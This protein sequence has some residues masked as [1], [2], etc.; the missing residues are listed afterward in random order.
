MDYETFFFT[1]IAS[2]TVFT[3]CL[4]LLAV[5][6]R[7]MVGLRWFAGALVVG[8]LKLILQGLEGHAP[9]V[10]T[11]MVSNELYLI[12]FAMQFLGFYWF[13]VRQPFRWRWPFV[14]LAVVLAVYTALFIG[15]VPYMGNVLNLPFI[16]LCGGSAWLL[17]RRGKGAFGRLAHCTA[18]VLIGDMGV[19]GYRAVLTNQHY[20]RPWETVNAHTDPRWLYSLAAMAFLATFMAM[21]FLWF[22]VAELGRVLEVQ[23]LTDPLTGA[24]NRRAMEEIALRETARSIRYGHPLSMI[25][26]DIDHFKYLND[27]RGHAAGDCALQALSARISATLRTVDHLARTG[28]EEFAILLPNTTGSIG[29]TVAERLRKTVEEMEIGFES[30]SLHITI[31]A[32]ITQRCSEEDGWEAMMRRADAAMYVAKQHGRNQVSADPPDAQMSH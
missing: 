21:C 31:S 2:V 29:L 6:Q 3:V 26:I 23:A 22:L 24:L 28:G 12:S 4:C 18:G 32:G 13:V 30:G 17:L 16:A 27:T 14:L 9:V 15:R 5:Y 7:A 11:S 8:L 20:V 10:L 25:I 1:N 19:A